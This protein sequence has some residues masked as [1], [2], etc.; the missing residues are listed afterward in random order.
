MTHAMTQVMTHRPRYIFSA[1][2]LASLSAAL[3][4]FT[5]VAFAVDPALMPL[6][7]SNP[8]AIDIE[9]TD[10]RIWLT[11][12]QAPLTALLHEVAKTT[13]FTLVILG[14]IDDPASPVSITIAAG[15]VTE[16]IAQLT[17][18]LSTMI[19]VPG[20]DQPMKLW[21]FGAPDGGQTK[22]VLK[23]HTSDAPPDANEA[24]LNKPDELPTELD[25]PN[26]L[27]RAAAL[28][29]LYGYDKE[30]AIRTLR[31]I[32]REDTSVVVR[33]NAIRMLGSLGDDDAY[34]ALTTGLGDEDS[35]LRQLTLTSLTQINATR[36]VQQMGAV[37]YNDSNPEV[38]LAA[39]NLLKQ[40]SNP[41][42]EYLLKVAWQDNDER[43]REAAK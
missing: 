17:E 13:G 27:I 30:V 2:C 7:S 10:G 1:L 38:R 34:D 42:A 21:V 39:V 23:Q 40:S 15:T 33:R 37:I 11:A 5:P 16:T 22:H 25:N 36:A 41:A 4:I 6:E 35:Q 29:Q 24:T 8:E 43:V 3:A 20:K 14:N 26:P 19:E 28:E 32:L 12:D 9:F 31:E 18:G